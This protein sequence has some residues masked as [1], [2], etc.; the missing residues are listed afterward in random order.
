SDIRKR[1]AA[2]DHFYD[3]RRKGDEEVAGLLHDLQVDIAIDL[4][5]HTQDWRPG[6]LAH[7]PAPIQVSYLGYPGTMDAEFIDY[8]VADGTVAPFEHQAFYAEKIVHLPDCYQVNDTRREI[9]TRTP[10]RQEA[11]LPEEGFVFC[12]FNNS[13]KITPPVF[14]VWMRLLGAVGHSVL[15][16]LR[17]NGDAQENLRK[18]AVARGIDP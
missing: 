17:D 5:G 9:A 6:I 15:W 3:V 4:K 1:L 8:I 11:G 16:L 10:T 2:F 13:Y 18:E 12:C 14:D 7:R